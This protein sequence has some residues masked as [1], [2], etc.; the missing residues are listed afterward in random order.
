MHPVL[1]RLGPLTI[2]TYGTLLACG[3]L[4]GL[5]LAQRRSRSAGLNPDDVW[6][7][8]VYMVLA[9]LLGAKVW[10]IFAFWDYYRANPGEILSVGT[11]QA[12]GVW[13]GGMLTGL[14]VAVYYTR[15]KKLSL[16]SLVDVY[17][18]PISMG[19]GIGRLGCFSAGCC[20]GR[21]SA[22]AWAVVFHDEYAHQLVGTPLGIPLH[23]TQLYEA[24]AELLIFLTLL[25]VGGRKHRTGQVFGTYAFLYGAARLTIE[26]FR[27]DPG[28]T[29][30][31]GGAVSIMQ[32]VSVG[33]MGLGIW[34][35]TRAAA[36]VP[37]IVA[38]SPAAAAVAK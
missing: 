24:F 33:L 4:L 12:G 16:L 32:I 23:P 10:L 27:G 31:F 20:Y 36:E 15:K 14:A 17:A 18:A 22:H 1:F 25:W 38:A 13:Y 8:G 34:L 30:L 6:N 7:F 3:I 37:A 11:L 19:H 9:A 29:L 21:P 2:H 35:W 26:F 5:W 28:R